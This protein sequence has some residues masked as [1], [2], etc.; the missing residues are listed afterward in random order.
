MSRNNRVRDALRCRHV[1]CGMLCIFDSSTSPRSCRQYVA[2]FW[3]YTPAVSTCRLFPFCPIR[4]V[5][6]FYKLTENGN[7]QVLFSG[8]FLQLFIF[9]FQLTE[10]SGGRCVAGHRFCFW[11]SIL[12]IGVFGIPHPSVQQLHIDPMPTGYL[13]GISRFFGFLN[14]LLF[15]LK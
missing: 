10:F 3:L 12:P 1:L 6:L 5:Y 11:R 14:Q 4:W 9:G 13:T 15:K 7:F 8:Q 2:R